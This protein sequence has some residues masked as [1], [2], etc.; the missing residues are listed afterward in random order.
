MKFENIEAVV[1][2]LDGTLI[3]SAPDLL[4][5][6]QAT[7]EKFNVSAAAPD[8]ILPGIAIGSDNMLMSAFEIAGIGDQK[9]LFD[10][11]FDWFLNYYAKNS[12]VKTRLFPGVRETLDA[13]QENGITMAVCTNKRMSLTLPIIEGLGIGGYFGAVTGRDSYAERKP[14]PLP[15]LE[16]LKKLDVTPESA[17]MIGDTITDL[18]VAQAC[19]VAS[20]C[21]TFGYASPGDIEEA[22]A[23][24]HDM[25]ELLPLILD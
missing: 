20:A 15:L 22:Y 3:D 5:G 6:I 17:V 2:D 4:D 24:I 14:H 13:L 25:P 12:L 11:A 7:L 19:N 9:E 8:D 16:T 18:K 10:E 23:L 1:F 21:V